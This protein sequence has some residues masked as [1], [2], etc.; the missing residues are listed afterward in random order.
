MLSLIQFDFAFEQFDFSILFDFS[1]Q[2][3]GSNL[4]NGYLT[5]KNN[6]TSA[7]LLTQ[8]K[9]KKSSLVKCA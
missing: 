8:A 4:K 2:G 3:E 5:I 1:S 6:I 9:Y 7:K